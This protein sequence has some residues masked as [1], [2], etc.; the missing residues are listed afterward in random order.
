M[1]SNS[2]SQA[3]PF[4]NTVEMIGPRLSSMNLWLAGGVPKIPLSLSENDD[5]VSANQAV[6]RIL[7]VEDE[8]FVAWLIEDIVRALNYVVCG[9][10]ASGEEAIEQSIAKNADLILMDINLGGTIDGV[11][12]ARRIRA[13]RGIKFIF[14]TAYADEAT[15]SRIKAA[16]PDALV[17]SKPVSPQHIRAAIL[18]LSNN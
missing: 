14:V 4:R 12:A 11:E 17:I 1:N 13:Q 10:V 2:L 6:P 3:L 15:N 16:V 7:I 5:N 8:I 18:S 9:I